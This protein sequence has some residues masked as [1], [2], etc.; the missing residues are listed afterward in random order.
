M[1]VTVAAV[2]LL[3]GSL[4]VGLGGSDTGA[5]EADAVASVPLQTERVRVEVL[6]A[7]GAPGLARSVTRSLRQTGNFDVVY[8][9][10]AG[11]KPLDVSV[12]VDR[13]GRP[14]RSRRVAAALQISTLRSEPDTLL[15]LDATVLLGRDRTPPSVVRQP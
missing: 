4:V 9:G 5:P 13:S 2:A 15:Y 8:Y 14:G 12:V 6:N 10:N 11:G 1:L 3:A 7:S